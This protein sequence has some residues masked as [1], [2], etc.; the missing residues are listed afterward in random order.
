MKEGKPV[1]FTG[2][3]FPEVVSQP[4]G[5]AYVLVVLGSIIICQLMRITFLIRETGTGQQ[6]AQLHD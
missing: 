1:Q 5:F 4:L 2:L 6:V 3:S